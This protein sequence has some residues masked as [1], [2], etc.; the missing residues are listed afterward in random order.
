MKAFP[1]RPLRNTRGALFAALAFAFALLLQGCLSSDDDA[2]VDPGPNDDENDTATGVATSEAGATIATVG[3]ASIVVPDGAVPLTSEGA[4]GTMAFSIEQQPSANATPPSGTA[5]ASSVY[6]FGPEGFVFARPVAVTVPVNGNPNAEDVR[7]YRVDPTSGQPIPWGGVYDPSTKTITAQTYELSQWFAA[8]GTWVGTQYGCLRV[9]NT[10]G[11]WIG[12]CV[13]SVELAFPTADANFDGAAS[14]WCGS[15]CF[16]WA[17]EGPWYLP[18]GTYRLCVSAGTPVAGNVRHY[19][20]DNVVIDQPWTSANPICTPLL[21]GTIAPIGG[22]GVEAGDCVCTPVVTP[23]VGTGDLQVTLTWH[24]EAPVDLDLWVTD[25]DGERCYYGNRTTVSGGTLDRDNYCSNYVNGRPEN[26]YWT[27]APSGVYAI[28]VN[29]YGNCSTNTTSMAYEV[30]VVN[31]GAVRTYGGTSTA[32]A[33]TMEVARVTVGSA[34][35][36]GASRTRATREWPQPAK[37]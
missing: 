22:N 5:V 10:S 2:P 3:G 17:S 6:R 24:S 31:R 28:E 20:I 23:S 26:I 34:P 14:A 30:R 8:V 1:A 9:S 7:L 11:E 32:A 29:W 4:S 36:A 12:V 25:P 33:P 18:Q 13:E 27:S 15:G 19:F 16:S 35:A 21:I 37:E